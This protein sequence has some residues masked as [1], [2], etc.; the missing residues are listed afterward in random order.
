M[1]KLIITDT[2]VFFDIMSIEILPDFFGLDF[3]ICTTDFVI[4]E[5]IRIDQAEQVQTFIRSKKLIVYKF[6]PQEVEEVINL[7]TKRNLRR[8]TDKS[9]LW[10]ALQLK[11]RLLTGDKNLKNEAEEQGLQV[12]GS[13]WVIKT[14]V[15]NNIVTSITAAE[16]LEKLKTVNESLPKDEIEKMIKQY[17][18]T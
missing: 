6:T 12:N 13:L 14:L 18:N 17:K 15:E 4:N 3:E 5:I 11:C 10:K 8:I 2:N 7:K 16:L 9:V 1:K